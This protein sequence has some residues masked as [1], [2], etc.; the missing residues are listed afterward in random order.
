MR[1]S[2]IAVT[3][4]NIVKPIRNHE[5]RIHQLPDR[6]QNRLE[7]VF[8]RLSS[9]KDVKGFVNVLK[10]KYQTMTTTH[11]LVLYMCKLLTSSPRIL[12]SISNRY[13]LQ[14]SHT[15][16]VRVVP[17]IVGFGSNAEINK[18]GEK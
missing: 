6:F 15:L 14:S 2:R 13:W 3:Q 4:K 5:F 11:H 7:I 17:G 12:R 18:V 16:N 10:S 9:N 1:R 8:F